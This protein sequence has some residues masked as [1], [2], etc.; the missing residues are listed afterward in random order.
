MP[1]GTVDIGGVSVS[2]LIMGGNPFSGFSHQSS[3]RDAEMR[4][5]YTTSRIKQTLAE[6]E[7]LG[8]N[9]QIARTDNHI[10][11]LLNEYWDEGGTIQWIAQTAPELRSA[12]LA[13]DRAVGNRAK[14]CFLHGG[15]TDN[16]YANGRLDE[17]PSLIGRIRRGGLAA[18]IAGHKPQLFQWARDRLDVDFYMCSHYNPSDR[19]QSAEHVPGRDERFRDDDRE[20]MADVIRSLDKPVIHY[21]ILAAGRNDPAEA[22]AYAARLMRPADAVCVGFFTKDK[23]AMIREDIELLEAGLAACEGS[24]ASAGEQASR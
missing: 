11:R 22:F 2:R 3:G 12:E 9:T 7:G 18:G 14:A 23:P 24:K 15:H 5:Y 10:V 8:I 20:A 13:I 17:L 1:L 6:A 19:R 4:H 16:A 21:K